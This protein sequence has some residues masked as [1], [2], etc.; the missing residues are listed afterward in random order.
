[1]CIY[2]CL[3]VYIDLRKTYAGPEKS[4]THSSADSP[5]AHSPSAHSPSAHIDMHSRYSTLGS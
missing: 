5:S 4:C 1:M 2:I 3:C